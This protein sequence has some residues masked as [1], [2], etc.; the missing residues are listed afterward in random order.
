MTSDPRDQ[1]FLFR[2]R[3]EHGFQDEP[4]RSCFLGKIFFVSE[5]RNSYYGAWS[6]TYSEERAFASNLEDAKQK[7][8]AWRTKGSQWTIAEL[9]VVVMSGERNCLV[10]GEINN[11]KLL[12]ESLPLEEPLLTLADYG[13]HFLPLRPRFAFGII[14]P[15]STVAPAQLPFWY[16]RSA[17]YGGHYPLGW[18]S[19]PDKPDFSTPLRIIY[20]VTENA[21]CHRGSRREVA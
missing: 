21:A 8:E 4:L 1:G 11:G 6:K 5:G 9:P 12:S 7:I 3:E 16:H 19:L 13:N 20:S 18:S 14:F 10:L 2:H 17:S 15:A